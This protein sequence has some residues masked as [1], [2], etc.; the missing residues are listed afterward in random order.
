MKNKRGPRPKW[1]KQHA[2]QPKL[3]NEALLKLLIERARQNGQTLLELA[4]EVGTTYSMLDK[5]RRGDSCIA[6]SAWEVQF[7]ISKYLNV[8]RAFV[9]LVAG[10]LTLD[11]F[12]WPG[13][14]QEFDIAAA[15]AELRAE[16]GIP[17]GAQRE[18]L[19]AA[20]QTRRL[21]SMLC[22]DHPPS[23]YAQRRT[24]EWLQS[25]ISAASSNR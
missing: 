18:L 13:E 12:G 1:F 8:P 23:N 19:T 3:T 14:P 6:R 22:G 25:L 4:R 9:L 15:L 24:D 2:A 5:W 20:V 10:G 21:A 11:D 17:G 7:A 16:T